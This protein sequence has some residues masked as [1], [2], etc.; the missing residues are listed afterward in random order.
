MSLIYNLMP[1][2]LI[3]IA[4][5]IAKIAARP[6]NG[7]ITNRFKHDKSLRGRDSFII[8]GKW[9]I[10]FE[11]YCNRIMVKGDEGVRLR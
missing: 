8:F 4:F 1:I 6:V 11:N 5:T 9:C 3:K 2:P 7:I 10:R